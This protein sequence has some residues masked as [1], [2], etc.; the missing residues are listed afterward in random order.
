[1]SDLPKR[2]NVIKTVSYDVDRI[3]NDL[4]EMGREEEI[5]IQV[6]L[7]YIQDWVDEDFGENSELIY[8]DENGGELNE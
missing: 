1:M 6:I 7:D 4:K 5:T 8:Q 3:V 2:I